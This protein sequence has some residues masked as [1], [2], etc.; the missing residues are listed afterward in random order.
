MSFP[1]QKVFSGIQE[2]LFL[3]LLLATFF[4]LLYVNIELIY[5]VGIAVIVISIIFLMTLAT[6][7]LQ[8][9]KE[10]AKQQQA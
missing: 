7:I 2:A 9:Q 3:A 6:Q 8:Q 5:K 10:A 1:N 4:A